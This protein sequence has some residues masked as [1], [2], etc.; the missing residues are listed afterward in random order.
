MLP[1][2]FAAPSCRPVSGRVLPWLVLWS[3]MTTALVTAGQPTHPPDQQSR[4]PNILFV[5]ADDQRHDV[6]GCAGDPLLQTPV[7][8]SLAGRGT[9]FTRAFVTTSICAASRASFLSGRYERSHGYT[10]GQR[11]MAGNVVDH[12]WPLRLRQA[13]YR[14]GLVG[15]F[16]VATAPDA[17]DRWF[18]RFQ[19][20]T[21]TPYWKQ[22]DDGTKR[23][24]TDIT[25][26]RAIEFLANSPGDQPF[27]LQVC[28][29]AAHAE[30]HDL[31]DHYPW[32]P[33]ADH[34]YQSTVFPEPSLNDPATLAAHPAFLM[35][36]LNRQ[37]FF[38][39][40]DTPDKYQKNIRGYYRMLSGMDHAIGRILAALD[41]RG[42]SG[43]T[44]V[45]FASDNGYY[46]GNRGFA[47]KWSHYDESLRIPLIVCD[48]RLS[49]QDRRP[50]ADGLVLNVDVPATL[51]DWAGVAA[52]DSYQGRSFR[53]LLSG[54]PP[55]DWRTDFF[56]EHLM[57]IGD[58]IPKWEGVRS[59]RYMYAR[60]FE[61]DP[62]YEFL[63]DLQDDPDQT[64][65]LAREDVVPG[66]LLERMRTRCDE[67][68]DDLGGPWSAERFPRRDR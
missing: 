31:L 39:R 9:R 55:A 8:D 59:G 13:G 56:C 10:F 22:L 54:D 23:H 16:G 24:V 2:S 38:W 65:N 21:R 34:L 66:E 46:M 48:P 20:L 30:D 33:A 32:P 15:K 3:A 12:A 29:N 40:W 36:S 11:P 58:K 27:C 49:Q 17:T 44:I 14:T 63:H 19:P 37:R 1:W 6:L 43:N 26:D 57:Q 7:I 53:P 5:L 25:A 52:P 62:A 60:Y 42:L 28:F 61:Q 18:D 64:V 51:L 35:N 4:R 50:L 67:L 45:V 41:E 68:R 47:G